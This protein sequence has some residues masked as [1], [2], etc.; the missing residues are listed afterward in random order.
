LESDALGWQYIS[1]GMADAHPFSYIMDLTAECKRLDPDG[2]YVRRW[3]PA[4]ALLPTEYIHAPW[5]APPEASEEELMYQ[6]SF[7]RCVGGSVS[8]K[9]VIIHC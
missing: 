9:L 5:S 6:R 7:S 1:G 4:L 8:F 2:E 3:L